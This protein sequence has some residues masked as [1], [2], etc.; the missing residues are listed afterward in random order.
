MNVIINED[1]LEGMQSL[2]GEQFEDTLTFCCDEFE[3]L[4]AE[5]RV[6]LKSN[7]QD[8]IRHAHSLKSNAAQFGALSL[9]NTARAIEQGLI[10]DDPQSVSDN[11]ACLS[12]QVTG[13]KTQLIQWL[14]SKAPL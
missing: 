1:A 2:L 4:E 7:K 6:A 3:R 12:D 9:S 8:A 13:S 5:L 11:V 14:S 10:N